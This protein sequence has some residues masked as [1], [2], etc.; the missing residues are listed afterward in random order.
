MKDIEIILPN[1]PGML[2]RLGELLGNN[3]I[4]LEGGGVFSNGTTA[5]AH[6]LVAEAEKAKEL[7][8]QGPFIS[9]RI[10]EVLILRLKQD[11]PGQL[12]M[13]AAAMAE[14][15]VNILVQYSDHA[16]QLIIVPDDLEKGRRVSEK[17]ASLTH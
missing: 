1:Q 10:N 7:L 12:G 8:S 3:G 9:V 2:A 6:F 16:G 4:S 14:A 13:F 11:V 15:G 17:W 5:I